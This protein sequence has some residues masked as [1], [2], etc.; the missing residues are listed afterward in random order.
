MARSEIF[1]V[2]TSVDPPGL[3]LLAG[4]PHIQTEIP[5]GQTDPLNSLT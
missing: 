2:E 1:T 5:N 3:A 4:C